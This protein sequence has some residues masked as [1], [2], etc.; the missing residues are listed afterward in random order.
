[1]KHEHLEEAGGLSFGAFFARW[2]RFRRGDMLAMLSF[3]V[4]F[5]L[6]LLAVVLIAG[7]LVTF[8]GAGSQRGLA[9]VDVF[10][11]VTFIG[12]GSQRSLAFVDLLAG[13]YYHRTAA[14]HS[15][16]I[17]LDHGAA[18]QIFG[19]I[20][21]VNNRGVVEDDLVFTRRDGQ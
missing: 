2:M 5:W 4:G 16:V 14:G 18:G 19:H 21:G 6:L 15:H 8:V 9:L 7:A 3:P 17:I 20:V 11:F 12:T 13:A 10:A 1:M